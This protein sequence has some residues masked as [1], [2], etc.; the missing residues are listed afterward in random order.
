MADMN[1]LSVSINRTVFEPIFNA[2]ENVLELV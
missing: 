2:D 1:F